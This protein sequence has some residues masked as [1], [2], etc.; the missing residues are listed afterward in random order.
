MDNS[1]P[2]GGEATRNDALI[3]GTTSL[4]LSAAHERQEIII[5]NISTAGQ[6]I[7]VSFGKEAAAGQGIFLLPGSSYYATRAE[8]FRPSSE[9][10]AAISSAVGGILAVFER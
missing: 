8:G 1:Y 6:N 3:I 2:F 5:T 7:S 10:V 9:F 4:Q